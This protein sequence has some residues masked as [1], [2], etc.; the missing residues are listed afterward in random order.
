[1]NI[2]IRIFALID[3]P[4]SFFTAEIGLTATRLVSRVS[5]RPVL[6]SCF[7]PLLLL[8]FSFLLLC[9]VQHLLLEAG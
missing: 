6:L 7:L 9:R 4:Y 3:V 2:V 5:L 1:V 8:F